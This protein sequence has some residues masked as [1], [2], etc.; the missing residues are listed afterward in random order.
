M[1][2][3]I[4]DYDPVTVSTDSHRAAHDKRG[5][6]NARMTIPC[7]VKVAVSGGILKVEGRTARFLGQALVDATEPTTEAFPRQ[8]YRH[9]VAGV[10][11][12]PRPMSVFTTNGNG[13]TTPFKDMFAGYVYADR[14]FVVGYDCVAYEVEELANAGPT[15]HFRGTLPDE[16]MKH[17]V[18]AKPGGA[19]KVMAG[20]EAVRMPQEEFQ[21]VLATG[22]FHAEISG[23]W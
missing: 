20:I 4:R 17:L 11:G 2:Y 18:Y 13:A 23:G 6:D 9:F 3:W 8:F 22:P 15:I 1:E 16:T 12:E 14:P 21:R 10:G 7:E 19:F 5:A